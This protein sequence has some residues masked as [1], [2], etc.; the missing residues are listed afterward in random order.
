ML[1]FEEV[2]VEVEVE[3]EL[4]TEGTAN[5]RRRA[6]VGGRDCV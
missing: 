2:E 6:G 3:A 1:S 5:G 4:Y